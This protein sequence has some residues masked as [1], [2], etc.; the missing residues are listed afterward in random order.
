M[1]GKALPDFNL[2]DIDGK[3]VKLADLKGKPIII[4]LW[5]AQ[6]PPC[7]AEMPTLSV[8]KEKYSSTDIQFLSMTYETK[9]A[10]K[11]FL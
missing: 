2:S 1:I 4:N 10:V 9:E 11:K 7:I 6:Y 5:F 8:I 3:L